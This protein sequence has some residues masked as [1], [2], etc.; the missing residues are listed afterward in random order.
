[1]NRK[2][3]DRRVVERH[4]E[5]GLIKE[6]DYASYLKQLPDEATNAQWVQMDLH[7]AE[8]SEG[9]GEGDSEAG[10]EAT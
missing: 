2:L 1:M 9:S 5:K 7:D 3:Y 6:T 4:V 10:D 8:I